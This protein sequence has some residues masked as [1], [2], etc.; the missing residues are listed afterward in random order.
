MKRLIVFLLLAALGCARVYAQATGNYDY[1][2]LSNVYFA[3]PAVQAVNQTL[4]AL[5]P[6]GEL[7]FRIRGL[8]NCVAD[9]YLAIFTVTQVGKTQREADELLRAKI[10]GIRAELQ[11]KGSAAEL[12]VDMISFLPI[13]ETE[14]TKKLFSKTTYNE[15]PIGFELKKNLHFRYRDASV[16]DELVT[17][18]AKLEIYDLVRV[19]YFIEDIE[20]K[21][22]P[23]M[24]RAEQL[25]EKHLARYKRITKEEYSS[26]VRQV[27]EG[28]AMFYPVEQYRKYETYHST[29]LKASALP[30]TKAQQTTTA[31]FFHPKL[32]KDYDFVINGSIFEPVVQIEYEVVFRLYQKPKEPEPVQQPKVVEREVIKTEREFYLITANG[33]IKKLGM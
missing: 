18:C 28:F 30:E 17:A 16:L 26:V 12:Y 32:S 2:E 8:S 20:A 33:E 27:G 3:H 13:Y 10:D 7:N 29:S 5:Q 9:S 6:A 24:A 23:L 19:D 11:G 25:L 14:G 15:I 4:A 21:K 22:A 31:Q 1:R